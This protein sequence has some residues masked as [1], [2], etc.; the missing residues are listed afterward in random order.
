M[1]TNMAMKC[2]FSSRYTEAWLHCGRA[3]AAEP[4]DVPRAGGVCN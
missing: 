3:I 4:Y 2:K 1:I